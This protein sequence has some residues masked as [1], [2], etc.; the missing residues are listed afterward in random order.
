MKR[1]RSELRKMGTEKVMRI[2]TIARNTTR[3]SF[4]LPVLYVITIGS[5]L[6]VAI[7]AQLPRFTLVVQDD[8]RMLKDLA[9]ATGT[10][11]GVLVAIFVAVNTITTEIEDW[12]VVT[13]LSKPV[14]R[15]EF[16]VGKFLGVVFTLTLVYAVLTVVYILLVWWGTW[17]SVTDYENVVPHLK[18]Q[19]WSIAMGT[20]NEMWRGMFL[21]LL[22]VVVLSAVAVA[23][24]VRAPMVIS[25]VIFFMMFVLGHLLHGLGEQG[26]TD[27][28]VVAAGAGM[29][30][31]GVAAPCG[32][33][34]VAAEASPLSHGV[35]LATKKPP[36]MAVSV[37]RAGAWAIPD[38]EVLNFSQEVGVGRIISFS[39]MGWALLYTLI[40][41]M[42]GVLT[43]L[44]LFQNRE[45]I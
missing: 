26:A 29:V 31:V 10:M 39:V 3:R 12:T 2:L 19:F 28:E 17:T 11:S 15:W 27:G 44:L 25:V 1:P 34:R 9:I 6:L 13:V 20:A 5:I 22:Q 4:H 23:C 24:C 32:P 38:L 30:A 7:V 14:R 36:R 43:A 45:V 41:S 21:C 37:A 42:V 33:A 35:G 8:I 40:Y 16:V 18:K